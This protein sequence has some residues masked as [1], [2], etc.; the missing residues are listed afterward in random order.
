MVRLIMSCGPYL[1]PILLTV[2]VIGLLTVVSGV[3]LLL[4]RRTSADRA[5]AGVNAIL[6]WGA[7]AAL[8]GFLGQWS[9]IYKGLRA[10]RELG[11]SSPRA[12]WVGIAETSQVAIL[13]LG[14]LL[15][16]GLIWLGLHSCWS[17]IG[18][19]PRSDSAVDGGGPPRATPARDSPS[20]SQALQWARARAILARL[21]LGLVVVC[22]AGLVSLVLVGQGYLVHGSVFVWPVIGI[23]LVALVLAV[24]KTTT[25]CLTA[26]ERWLQWGQTTMVFLAVTSFGLGIYGLVVE[27]YVAAR[28]IMVDVDG[29]ALHIGRCLIGSSATLIVG[30]LVATGIALIWFMLRSAIRQVRRAED[31]ALAGS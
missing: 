5:R 18:Q 21:L 3:R 31:A 19:A 20:A 28:R 16:A 14:I 30:M 27:L 29:M 25:L 10:I 12:V 23:G 4:W 1:W 7:V 8:L 9:G 11:L 24:A 2:G 26:E 6:F 13:G 22:V 17:R 15:L